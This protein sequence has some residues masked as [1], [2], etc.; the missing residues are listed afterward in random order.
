MKISGNKRKTHTNNQRGLRC[1][2]GGRQILGLSLRRLLTVLM[3]KGLFFHESLRGK[4]FQLRLRHGHSLHRFLL[5]S[6]LVPTQHCQAQKPLLH[7][8]SP[9]RRRSESQAQCRRG[10]ETHRSLWNSNFQICEEFR[11]FSQGP[12]YLRHHKIRLYRTPPSAI[13]KTSWRFAPKCITA[14]PG[15]C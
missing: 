11:R 1:K 8:L 15:T 13:G 9:R 5:V 14:L 4:K 10:G 7:I 6:F 2:H 3:T 12:S